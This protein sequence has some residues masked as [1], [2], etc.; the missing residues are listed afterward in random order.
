[1]Q[2]IGDDCNKVSY[3]VSEGYQKWLDIFSWRVKQ[4][5]AVT[6]TGKINA[7]SV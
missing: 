5:S 7:G 3:G 4:N 1:M 2:I 6:N